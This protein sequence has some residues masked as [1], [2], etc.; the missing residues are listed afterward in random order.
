MSDFTRHTVSKIGPPYTKDEIESLGDA[1]PTRGEYCPRCETYIPS[2]ADLSANDLEE[3]R[4]LRSIHLMKAIRE[5]T[6]CSHVWAKIWALHPDGPHSLDPSKPC[7][8]CDLPLHVNARQCLL[9]KM[10]WHDPEN[11]VQLGKSIAEQIMTAPEG[12]TI[13]VAGRNALGSAITYAKMKR[14]ND[15]LTLQLVPLP[16]SNKPLE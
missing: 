15:S 5:K 12:A 2:F 3:L 9:C 1:I 13:P 7:P 11:P 6:G 8:Y 16:N 14:P 10:N 4:G